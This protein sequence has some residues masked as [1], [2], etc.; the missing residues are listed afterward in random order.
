MSV[1]IN[2]GK[3]IINNT[4]RYVFPCLVEHSV[5]LMLK[6]K[7]LYKAF[8]GIGDKFDTLPIGK[9]IYIVL[10][11]SDRRKGYLENVA[12]FLNW[13]SE[14]DY[15]VKDYTYSTTRHVV[16]LELPSV[17]E[18]AIFRCISGDYKGLYTKEQF[19]V[20]YKPNMFTVNEGFINRVNGGVFAESNYLP[21]FVSLVNE[22]FKTEITV[23][24]YKDVEQYEIQLLLPEEVLNY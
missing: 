12:N 9:Y 8:V 5:E 14:K 1:D 24:D 15:Y 19:D 22:R 11:T 17:H 18:D 20:Y 4:Y 23:E 7:T 13:I 2:S 6:L 10:D 16:V 21:T 3:L